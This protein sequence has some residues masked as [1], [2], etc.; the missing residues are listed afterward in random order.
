[1]NF[2][3]HGV[4]HVYNQGNNRRRIFFKEENYRYFIRKMRTHLLPY[5]D[6]L[7][8]CLM[9]NHFHWLIHVRPEAC[10][11]LEK[12]RQQRLSRSIGTLLSS[13]SQGI[14]K[15]NNSSGSL[16]RAKTKSKDGDIESK[17]IT[18]LHDSDGV[19]V[20]LYADMLYV[21]HCIN[22]IHENPVEA[23]LVRNA[24]DWPYSSAG[25]DWLPVLRLP[26]V[27]GVPV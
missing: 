24:E 1:M 23:G 15:Q 3:E 13:Y 9:P 16:F 5:G 10:V 27:P 18:F 7:A 6:L 19:M 2:E 26:G 14:N 12:A 21:R 4:Y 11:L 20:P 8:Y 17:L 25:G 22:Y